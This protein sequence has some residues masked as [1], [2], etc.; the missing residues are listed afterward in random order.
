MRRI[1]LQETFLLVDDESIHPA[2]LAASRVLCDRL[3]PELSVT[4]AGVRG[5]GRTAHFLE[6]GAVVVSQDVDDALI[7]IYFCFSP[8]SSPYPSHV[9]QVAIFGGTIEV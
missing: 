4:E 1:G 5:V 2:P 3:G 9:P 6:S 8:D 7:M